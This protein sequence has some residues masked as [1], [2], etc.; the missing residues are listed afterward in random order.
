MSKKSSQ[1]MKRLMAFV[2]VLLMTCSSMAI[3][4]VAE[5]PEPSAGACD[6]ADTTKTY[7]E[8]TY[9]TKCGL[10][11]KT[12]PT[13]TEEGKEV[14]NCLDENCANK[15]VE[16]PIPALG[17]TE[18][19][20]DGTRVDTYDVVA[21]VC[22][23][24][25][26]NVKSGSYKYKCAI[27]QEEQTV[28]VKPEH[29]WLA[30]TSE[31]E[32]GVT[33]A[34][35][36]Q[37]KTFYWECDNCGAKMTTTEG[38]KLEHDWSDEKSI[39]GPTCAKEGE[40]IEYQV[41]QR[42]GCTATNILN[43]SGEIYPKLDHQAELNDLI[44]LQ[45]GEESN[46]DVAERIMGM[47]SEDGHLPHHTVVVNSD[48]GHQ[49]DIDYAKVEYVA[50]GCSTPGS[51]T[52]TC[53]NPDCGASVSIEIEPVGHDYRFVQDDEDYVT[54]TENGSVLVYCQHAKD[55]IECDFEEEQIELQC[56]GNHNWNEDS[57][58]NYTYTQ[59]KY[60]DKE[61]VEYAK[62]N[63]AKCCDYT[64][65][66]DCKGYS[67]IVTLNNG[68]NLEITI[69]CD[70]TDPRKVTGTDKHT[71]PTD[72]GN[73]IH[74]VE[75]G[76]GNDG[77][78]IYYCTECGYIEEEVVPANGLHEIEKKVETY[79]TCEEKG[80]YH[81][82]CKN[83]DYE[84]WQD[85]PALGHKWEYE[86]EE[87]KEGWVETTKMDCSTLTPGVMTRKCTHCKKV[88]TEEIPVQ[89]S[90]PDDFDEK[91][92]AGV[93]GYYYKAPT[94][95]EDGYKTYPCAVCHRES[96]T[97]VLE[98][99]GHTWE[100]E[101]WEDAYTYEADNGKWYSEMIHAT[102]EHGNQYRRTCDCGKVETY[103]DDNTIPCTLYLEDGELAG[104]ILD[105][106]P[107]CE[108]TGSARFTCA[109]CRHTA[110]ITLDALPHNHVVVFNEETRQYERVCIP[111]EWSKWEKLM[112]SYMADTI[113]D[114][115][116]R[117]KVI[118]Q[119]E[120]RIKGFDP[121][122]ITGIGCDDTIEIPMN[123]THYSIALDGETV[124]IELDDKCV[125]LK[126]PMIRV[127]W[128]YSNANDEVFSYTR[129]VK[130]M[131]GEYDIGESEAPRG[132]SLDSFMVIVVDQRGLTAAEAVGQGYGY[133]KY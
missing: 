81:I 13:C 54:C 50:P 83:C 120:K 77:Y 99:T 128:S 56:P 51:L 123:K 78:I 21:A 48:K 28:E 68:D 55:G 127:T 10:V 86:T 124:T 79:P 6:H 53:I 47:M 3:T 33:E 119:I 101:G 116:V 113:T 46:A 23:P 29:N 59:K 38:E 74:E 114:E 97:T 82:T 103:E 93:K 121:D 94:C 2:L 126:N 57:D 69:A 65:H 49:G 70:A 67:E 27:C 1:V 42:E 26:G 98:A 118:D 108:N 63:I 80:Q 92:N 16:V 11:S 91:F 40:W 36:D 109:V 30:D 107:T 125:G 4:A 72:N 132:Y 122:Y 112:E 41:C 60:G 39:S 111:A 37:P 89:H 45:E 9:C 52:I 31:H 90:I 87:N 130:A 73:I 96:Q 84:E 14:Y 117:R 44:S 100:R 85:I 34:T 102:C 95:E 25:E 8:H 35:C 32:G 5:E 133:V 12:E 75:V 7:G 24:E 17:H 64:K 88:E 20:A 22:G 19:N 131:D 62:E 110:E 66:V 129:Y 76:C 71:V 106:L 43:Q 105:V 15:T 104:F 18:Y 115:S 58:E 61:E